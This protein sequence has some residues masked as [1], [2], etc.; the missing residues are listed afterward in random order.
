[1]VA[2][3]KLIDS[4]C[5]LDFFLKNP[6]N[7][8]RIF[9][10]NYKLPPLASV[11]ARAY[12]ANVKAILT[13]ATDLSQETTL[14]SICKNYDPQ[15]QDPSQHIRVPIKRAGGIIINYCPR[16]FC[17]AG[18]H[19]IS[20]KEGITAPTTKQLLV[21][22]HSNPKRIIAF[23]ESGLDYSR[24]D[25]PPMDLQQESF[26]NH[27]FAAQEAQIPLVIHNRNADLELERI[28]I[29]TQKIKPYPCILHCFAASERLASI[30]LELC[31]TLSFA[32]LVTYPSAK[33]LGAIVKKIPLS[34]LL[35]ETDSPFLPPQ[36]NSSVAKKPRPSHSEPSMLNL[37]ASHVANLKGLSL[38]ELAVATSTNF[39]SLFRQNI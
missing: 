18:T 2:D 14:L 37:T 29:Q 27:I 34:S 11:L 22:H 24:T 20:L 6:D 1:M 31:C 7:S 26:Y 35:I 5:H 3:F 12:H 28:L 10:S 23:G 16:L 21:A 32:G 33:N 13:I 36:D 9:K 4:H 30:A 38:H 15:P 8:K 25:N 39:M 17:S 19:P